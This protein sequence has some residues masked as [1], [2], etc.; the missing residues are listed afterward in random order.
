MELVSMD[1]LFEIP[2]SVAVCPYCDAK[3]TASCEA[4]TEEEEGVWQAEG[5]TV[6]C[7]DMPDFESN[8]WGDWWD[9]HYY[10]PYVYQLPVDTKV[11]RWIDD[12]FRFRDREVPRT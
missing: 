2:D 9:G 1:H 3:L 5:V 8:E 4:W 7:D 6:N 10:M 12:N 11:K